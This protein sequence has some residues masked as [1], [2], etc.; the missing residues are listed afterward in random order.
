MMPKRRMKP[1]IY[2][3][4]SEKNVIYTWLN[5]NNNFNSN[6]KDYLKQVH[7]VFNLITIKT[8]Y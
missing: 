6:S 3:M 8:L 5:T 1:K 4:I 2:G 7:A